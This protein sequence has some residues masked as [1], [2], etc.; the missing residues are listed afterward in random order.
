MAT[1]IIDSRLDK[2]LDSEEQ[3]IDREDYVAVW[4]RLWDPKKQEFS[5]EIAQGKG[6][7]R[8]KGG[9][10]SLEYFEKVKHEELAGGENAD[11]NIELIQYRY[12]VP[13]IVKSRI[14]FA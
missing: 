4:A 11:I 9:T 3:N 6:I 10:D 5:I 14:L 13:R 1:A 8:F 2:G 7:K 12:G